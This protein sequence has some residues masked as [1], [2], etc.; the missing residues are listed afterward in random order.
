M[1]KGLALLWVS[2]AL[3]PPLVVALVVSFILWDASV[4]SPAAWEAPLRFLC[5]G[6]IAMATIATP[7]WIK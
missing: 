5:A 4:L 3:V 6:W 1:L 7:C 2:M